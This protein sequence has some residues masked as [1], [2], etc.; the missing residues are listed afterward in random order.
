MERMLQLSCRSIRRTLLGA[1]VLLVA[2]VVAG[3]AQAA[4]GYYV[5]AQNPSESM[6]ANSADS[7]GMTVHSG[8][9]AQQPEC[10]CNG[11]SC[12]AHDS[13]IPPAPMAQAG[14]GDQQFADLGANAEILEQPFTIAFSSPGTPGPCVYLSTVDP[15]PRSR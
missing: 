8:S 6:V 15:P 12:R 14:A 1:A 9:H 10:P 2:L 5:V 4:C 11:P 13:S 3:R 7:D